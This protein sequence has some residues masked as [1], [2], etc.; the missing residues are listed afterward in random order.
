[1]NGGRKPRHAIQPDPHEADCLERSLTALSWENCALASQ[2]C[3]AAWPLGI[4]ATAAEGHNYQ[5][6]RYTDISLAQKTGQGRQS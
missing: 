6:S 1:M 2:F 3:Q 5:P 4:T